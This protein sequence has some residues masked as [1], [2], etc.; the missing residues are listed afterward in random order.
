MDAT[1]YPPRFAEPEE[2]LNSP[3]L[4]ALQAN[5]PRIA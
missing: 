1:Q 5:K 3:A 4:R 2:P